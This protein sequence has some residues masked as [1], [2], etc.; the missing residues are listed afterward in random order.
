MLLEKLQTKE[1][2]L[3]RFRA[4]QAYADL[5]AELQRSQTSSH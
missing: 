4:T 3:T 1:A 5:D 2:L